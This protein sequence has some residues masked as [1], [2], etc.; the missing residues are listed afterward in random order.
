LS[1]YWA[2]SRPTN[3]TFR[4]SATVALPDFIPDLSSGRSDRG[5][6]RRA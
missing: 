3:G 6:T 2:R 4:Q 1:P 5:P